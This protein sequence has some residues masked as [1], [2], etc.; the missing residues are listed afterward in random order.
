MPPNATPP[1][2][3]VNLP[4]PV[5]FTHGD[6]VACNVLVTRGPHPRVAA[7]IDWAHAGWYPWYWEWCK[8]KWVRMPDVWEEMD[9]AAQEEWQQRWLPLVVGPL[10]DEGVYYPWLRFALAHV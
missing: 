3:P 7:V 9:D 6:V 5:V 1:T 2:H 8:A 4:G 10:P